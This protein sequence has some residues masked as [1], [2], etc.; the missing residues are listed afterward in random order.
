LNQKGYSL[1]EIAAQMNCSKSTVGN[2]LKNKK[3]KH[4]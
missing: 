4:P 3:K 1:R 2:I